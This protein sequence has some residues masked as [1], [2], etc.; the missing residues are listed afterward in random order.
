MPHLARMAG[1]DYLS[2]GNAY[3]EALPKPFLPATS[4]RIAQDKLG[5]RIGNRSIEMAEVR[6][7]SQHKELGDLFRG[8]VFSCELLLGMPRFFIIDT[9]ETEK[10]WY[11]HPSMDTGGLQLWRRLP[12]SGDRSYGVWLEPGQTEDP[13]LMPV[14]GALLQQH[15]VGRETQLF[16]ALCDGD[17]LHVAL[18]TEGDLFRLGGLMATDSS[19]KQA[20]VEAVQALLVPTRMMSA[21]LEA[22]G[23]AREAQRFL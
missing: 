14:I 11:D 4:V 17:M 18:R 8:I 12:G 15:W 2:D 23:K 10:K 20:M 7:S 22:E 13:A 1:L 3:I 6:L 16:S 19:I 9:R 5:K 21:V